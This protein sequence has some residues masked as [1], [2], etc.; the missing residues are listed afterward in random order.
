MAH[1]LTFTTVTACHFDAQAVL[2]A[3]DLE[4]AF[5]YLRRVGRGKPVIVFDVVAGTQARRIAFAKGAT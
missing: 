1:R 2:L 5:V 4:A 3:R